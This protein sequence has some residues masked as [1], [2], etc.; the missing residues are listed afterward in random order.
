MGKDLLKKVLPHEYL[1]KLKEN[2]ESKHHFQL[3]Y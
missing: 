2:K 3:I 1:S